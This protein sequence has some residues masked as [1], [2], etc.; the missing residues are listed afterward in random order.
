M[1][2]SS[3]I[4]LPIIKLFGV[5]FSLNLALCLMTFFLIKLLNTL[6]KMK[7]Q[8]ILTD[9]IEITFIILVILCGRVCILSMK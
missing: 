3:L 1:I 4:F 8:L 9:R 5:N 2:E 6:F 7:L